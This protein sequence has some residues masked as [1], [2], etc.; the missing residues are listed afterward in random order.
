METGEKSR[1]RAEVTLA[2][3]SLAAAL[4]GQWS[5]L[6]TEA[7]L[8]GAFASYLALPTRHG[9]TVGELALLFNAALYAYARTSFAA[10][11][12]LL[13]LPGFDPEAFLAEATPED[14]IW[15]DGLAVGKLSD[16]VDLPV[17]LVRLRVA[18]TDAFAM[19]WDLAELTAWERPDDG[20]AAP[21]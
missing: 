20:L 15:C 6:K 4:L 7:G 11:E 21:R 3:I 1:D 2:L 16:W 10:N 18:S 17:A 12:R 9:M 5:L 19:P 13:A 8:R 14:V